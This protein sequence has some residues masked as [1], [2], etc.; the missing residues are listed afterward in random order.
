MPIVSFKEIIQKDPLPMGKYVLD[1]WIKACELQKSIRPKRKIVRLKIAINKP[2]LF[3][4]FQYHI[5]IEHTLLTYLYTKSE[6][7]ITKLYIL[8]KP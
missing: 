7:L 4:N 3:Y 5:L 2:S 6:R 1:F 8:N